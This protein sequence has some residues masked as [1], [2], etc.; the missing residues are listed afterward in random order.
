MVV[1]AVPANKDFEVSTEKIEIFNKQTK[2]NTGKQFIK[3]RLK[4]YNKN[5]IQWD[6]KKY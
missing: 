2:K 6:M 3:N 4:K 1:M 5:D